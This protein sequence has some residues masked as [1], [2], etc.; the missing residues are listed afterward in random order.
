[1]R[2]LTL[3]LRSSTHSQSLRTLTILSLAKPSHSLAGSLLPKGRIS[4]TIVSDNLNHLII[5]LLL[6]S[7]KLAFSVIKIICLQCNPKQERSQLPLVATPSTRLLFECTTI[8]LTINSIMLYHCHGLR[9]S[10]SVL[11]ICFNRRSND[12]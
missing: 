10:L 12:E 8:K 11:E 2:V 5:I 3:S 6:P 4:W 1:M 7:R 9:V